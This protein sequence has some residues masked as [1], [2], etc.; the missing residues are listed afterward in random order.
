MEAKKV[1]SELFE[2]EVKKVKG[3]GL[4]GVRKEKSGGRQGDGK[5][6]GGV[7]KCRMGF[8]PSKL[9]RAEEK[10]DS[11]CSQAEW[12]GNLGEWGGRREALV[13]FITLE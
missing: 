13:P 2:K 11:S 1:W 3:L 9:S 8:S 4:A 12:K 10:E 5:A 6:R 7:A